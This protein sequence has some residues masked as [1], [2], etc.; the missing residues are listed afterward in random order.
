MP[1]FDKDITFTRA[2]GAI[3]AAEA[4]LTCVVDAVPRVVISW[5]RDSK[6]DAGLNSG[7]RILEDDRIRIK[8]AQIGLTKYKV[9]DTYPGG[10][11]GGYGRLALMI[12]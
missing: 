3:G 10:Q 4:I 7:T 8:H 6:D 1:V 9:G 12:A 2:A 5:H 11:D